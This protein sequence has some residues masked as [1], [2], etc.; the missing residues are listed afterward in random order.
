MQQGAYGQRLAH[1]FHLND[2]PTLQVSTD[3]GSVL[4]VTELRLD[5][6]GCGMTAPLGHDD[7]YLVCLQLRSLHKH[8]LWLDGT[9]LGVRSSTAGMSCIHDLRRNP[10]SW[11]DEPFHSLQFYIPRAALAEIADEKGRSVDD[12]VHEPGKFVDDTVINGVGRCL[13]PLMHERMPGGQL[14]V[15]HML[16]ALRGHLLAS[17]GGVCAATTTVHGGL[18]PWQQRRATELMREHVVD[19]ITLVELARA[20]RLSSSAFVRAFKQSMGVPPH[21]WLLL[22]RIDHAIDLM[23]D[24]TMQLAEVALSAGF[25]DQSHFTRIFARKMGVSPGAWRSACCR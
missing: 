2:P 13:L 5:E 23:R 20:C 12:L 9:A 25:A 11:L 16:L 18:A 8:E 7:A 22:R 17:Y 21:Q 10:V 14:F 15:D 1:S 19:G 3:G 24:H 4:A 6:S